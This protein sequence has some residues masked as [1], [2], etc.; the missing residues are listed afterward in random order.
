M[1]RLLAPVLPHPACTFPGCQQFRAHQSTLETG[2]SRFHLGPWLSRHQSQPPGPTQMFARSCMSTWQASVQSNSRHTRRH[3]LER[4][5]G[6]LPCSRDPPTCM[7]LWR[8]A[9]ITWK[10]L[11][12]V[13]FKSAIRLCYSSPFIFFYVGRSLLFLFHV[14]PW[15]CFTDWNKN[16]TWTLVSKNL[17]GF[18]VK[19]NR[20]VARIKKFIN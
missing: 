4:F 17:T 16:R 9:L 5:W 7:M 18:T 3:L 6:P 12:M 8:G 2:V 10:A 14:S 1:P 20:Q 19:S 13:R 15:E 11:M